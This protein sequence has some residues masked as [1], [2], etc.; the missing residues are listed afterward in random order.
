MPVTN[1]NLRSF[2]KKVS[3]AERATIMAPI[4]NQ[5]ITDFWDGTYTDGVDIFQEEMIDIITTAGL[6]DEDV[7]AHATK[8]GTHPCNRDEAMLVPIDVHDLLQIF[9][10]KGWVWRKVDC[11]G[12]RIPKK[13]IG[14]EWRKENVRLANGSDELLAPVDNPDELEILT[15]RGS[16]TTAAIRCMWYGTKGIHPETMHEGRVSKSKICEIQPSMMQPLQKGLP[17]KLVK[18]ELVEL[19]PHLMKALSRTG[20]SDHGVHR[21]ET[22]LQ[23]CKRTHALI[24]TRIAENKKV[25]KETIIKL[26]CIGENPGYENEVATPLYDFV[27]CHSGGANGE[28]LIELEEYER[29]LMVKRKILPTDLTRLAQITIPEA[30]KWVPMMVKAML[31]APPSMVS[32]GCADVFGT[33]DISSL[34]TKGKNQQLAIEGAQLAA[35]AHEFIK[36]YGGNKIDHTTITKLRGELEVRTVMHVHG[37]NVPHRKTYQS[38]LHIASDFYEDVKAIN[39]TLPQWP[40]LA[41]FEA[42]KKIILE[43]GGLRELRVDG[44]IPNNELFRL[45]LNYTARLMTKK[46]KVEMADDSA[47]PL[48]TYKLA[49]LGDRFSV[50]LDSEQEGPSIVVPRVKLVTE[51]CTYVEKET[52]ATS[53]DFRKDV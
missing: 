12:T 1:N 13:T 49:S 53:H 37:K 7:W 8:V 29:L 11:L 20:N 3:T 17:Y 14:E 34:G 45:G 38:I 32:N 30:P 15:V 16:H 52:E 25:D 51:W 33:T 19:C 23:A 26:A 18:S 24:K 46:Y 47:L 48:L 21:V 6:M 43:D 27:R 9:A 2:D 31:N 39:P 5:M 40:R 44:S 42:A 22:A 50:Q 28:F 4:V 36:A 10:K 35:D 41:T